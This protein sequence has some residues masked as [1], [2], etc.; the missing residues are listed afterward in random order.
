VGIT[1]GNYKLLN[2][3]KAKM[4]IIMLRSHHN[5]FGIVETS[6]SFLR[7]RAD[8]ALSDRPGNLL[9]PCYPPCYM[10]NRKFL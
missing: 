3:G 9:Q 4:K 5:G 1:V 7:V 2:N 8:T 10:Y 6:L